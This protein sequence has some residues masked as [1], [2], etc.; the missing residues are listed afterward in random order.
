MK[1][2]AWAT[3]A[4][5]AAAPS[6]VRA[7]EEAPGIRFEADGVRVGP[8]LVQ[9]PVLELKSAGDASLLA[10][11]S[12]IEAL[13]ACLEVDLAPERPLT[14]EPGLRVTRVEGGYRF[15]THDGRR[16]RFSAGAGLR[17]ASS[18]AVVEV[19]QG[20]WRIE[21]ET[22]EGMALQAGRPEPPAPG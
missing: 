7:A 5:L 9:G 4:L 13:T 16:I 20:A 14:L 15:S 12:S 11:G 19:T 1:L 8:F 2:L 21:G 10:S 6:A 22:L 3:L 18:P 17:V